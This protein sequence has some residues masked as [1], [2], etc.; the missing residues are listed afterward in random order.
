MRELLTEKFDKPSYSWAIS[1][2]KVWENKEG[3][4]HR[5][6]DKPAIIC[7]DGSRFWYKNGKLHRNNG[8]PAII[9]FDGSMC[10]LKKGKIIKTDIKD[11]FS[12]VIS[13]T[14]HAILVGDSHVLRYDK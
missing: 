4:F 9:A 13:E 8:K 11:M 2:A 7:D 1:P 5:D 3:Q 10:W 14:H 6:D 12:I